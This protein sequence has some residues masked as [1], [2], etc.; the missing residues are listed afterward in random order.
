[1]IG[2][3]GSG[4]GLYGHIPALLELGFPVKT[5]SRYQA[6]LDSRPEL[7]MLRSSVEFVE[8]ETDV[9][10]DSETVV[11]ARR[12]VDNFRAAYWF[13]H[14]SSLPKLVIEK[15]LGPTPQ[16]AMQFLLDFSNAQLFTPFLFRWCSWTQSL[17]AALGSGAECITI[18]WGFAPSA[19]GSRW[20]ADVAAGGG[21]LAYYF[22]HL[23]AVLTYLFSRFVVDRFTAEHRGSAARLT[24]AVRSEGRGAT[25]SFEAGNERS[26]FRVLA[27]NRLIY[28]DETSF[29][30]VPKF[31][32]R[33]PRIDVLKEFYRG[34][35]FGR[36]APSEQD[37]I[38][39]IWSELEAR[40]SSSS[41]AAKV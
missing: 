25:V 10:A 33:D 15:P 40:T 14:C 16:E 1:L 12:P 4:F 24:L 9:L 30:P 35:V 17:R 41:A 21:P 39:A 29:G 27:D 34:E 32:V 19:A 6:R 23:I 26:F 36:S 18:E 20:K 31:G 13:R 22:V 37:R 2:V 3:L 11:L 7:A 5:L 38:V 28:D 8:T